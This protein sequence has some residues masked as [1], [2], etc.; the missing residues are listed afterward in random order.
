MAMIRNHVSET[1]H[2][3]ESRIHFTNNY[4]AKYHDHQPEFRYKRSKNSIA[5]V[6]LC[7]I[8]SKG[9]R[10][11]THPNKIVSVSMSVFLYQIVKLDAVKNT[12]SLSGSFE[13][14]FLCDTTR[15]CDDDSLFHDIR[16]HQYE[17][18]LCL[19]VWDSFLS[20]ISSETLQTH[21]L[22]AM[23][24]AKEGSFEFEVQF[25]DIA[26]NDAFFYQHKAL[27]GK[28]AVV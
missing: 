1:L 13:L 16:L 10:P 21:R 23:V 14:P 22:R 18:S 5:A 15:V 25:D 12:I 4:F 20:E 27:T 7:Q 8:D 11:V 28:L 2:L 9:T 6:Y 3:E 19:Q 17:H 24:R 26:S